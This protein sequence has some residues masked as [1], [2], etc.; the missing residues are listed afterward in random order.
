[1][2]L[3]M[4]RQVSLKLTPIAPSE[5]QSLAKAMGLSLSLPDPSLGDGG[6]QTFLNPMESDYIYI[7]V[8]ALTAAS[9]QS[10]T[11]NFGH[12]GGKAL[13]EAVAKF[14]DLPVLKD[15]QFSVDNWI[16]RTQNAFWDTTTPGAP[17]GVTLMMKVDAKADPKCARGLVS[18][19]LDSVSV[20]VQFDY[21]QSHPNMKPEDFFWKMGEIVDGKPVQALVT[22]V[23]RLYELSVVWQGADVFAKSVKEDG[24]HT[25]GLQQHIPTKP[26]P[27]E[28][29]PM[30]NLAK[31][32]GLA[33]GDHSEDQLMA[34]LEDSIKS[35]TAPLESQLIVLKAEVEAKDAAVT[36]LTTEVTE[37]KATV[38][39]LKAELETLK[40]KAT[41]GD[42][43]LSE[44]RAEAARLYAIVAD[45]KQDANL[46]KLISEASLE[47]AKG[48]IATFGPQ[49]EAIAPLCCGSCGS[50]NV[51]RKA[52]QS[53]E[54][55]GG[56]AS[57]VDK[58]KAAALKSTVSNMH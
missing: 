36:A 19:M 15:H 16:G 9:V 58:A 7:P 57:Y 31:R 4:T 44:Q 42:T 18:G 14:N 24:I 35:M 29:L 17:P 47:T 56:S 52:S 49:A 13:Q 51:S 26:T 54:L 27:K 8:R 11:I 37:L 20:T 3:N 5:T 41:L 23:T 53:E 25:P 40:P 22:D 10:D 46:T 48:F 50:K 21:E 30:K 33:E 1:M 39:P 2:K 12:L 38:E 6:L 34:A 55:H 43:F 28:E 32:L 45:G